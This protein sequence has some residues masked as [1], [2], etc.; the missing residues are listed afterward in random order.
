MRRQKNTDGF[1]AFAFDWLVNQR[2]NPIQRRHL[3]QRLTR[4]DYPGLVKLVLADLQRKDSGGFGSLEIHRLLL[5]AQLDEC[6]AAEPGLMNK[7]AFVSTYLCKLVP[8]DDVD[9]QYDRKA[10]VAY[11]DRVWEFVEPLDPAFN[12]LK[13]HVLYRRL[14]LDRADGVYDKSRFM[15]Y[16]KLPRHASYINPRFMKLP[17]SR[18]YAVNL[19]YDSQGATLLPPIG[20]DEPLVRS[21]L[22]HFFVKETGYKE[23]EPYVA[24]TYLKR[25]FAETKITEGSGDAVRWYAML[26]P[27]EVQALKDRIDLEFVP[28][29]L[30]VFGVD[31]E[32]RLDMHVKNVDKLIVKVF[33]INTENYYRERGREVNTDI[34]LDGLVANEEFRFEYDVPSER[35]VLRNFAFP[36]LKDRGVYVI[37]FIGN[38]I[39]SRAVVRK[40]TLRYLVRTGAAGQEFTVLNEANELVQNA[41][42]WIRGQE[43]EAQENGT[44]I[45]PFSTKPGR[46][47]LVISHDGLA[48]LHQFDHQA[49]RYEL[50]AGFYVDR[51]ALLKHRE[52]MILVRPRLLVN[53]TPVGLSNLENVRLQ[54]VSVDH[55]GTQTSKE[56]G[57]FKLHEDRESTY[58]IQ[59]PARLAALTV[60]LHAEIE[61]LS[62]NKKVPLV[63]TKQWTL[64]E[65]DRT[66]RTED[67]H[68]FQADGQYFLE[69]LGRS[70]EARPQR[71]VRIELQHRD[72][73]DT[74]TTTLQSDEAGQIALGQLEDIFRIRA[75]DIDGTTREFYLPTDRVAHYGTMHGI[76]G[77]TLASSLCRRQAQSSGSF[78][79]IYQSRHTGRGCL[80][81]G[82]VEQRVPLAERSQTG[83]LPADA[84]TRQHTN[85]HSHDQ[86]QIGPA[87]CFG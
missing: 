35:R 38:G 57:D 60:R 79:V 47:A 40:G 42:I 83:E 75:T 17:E 81:K 31:D 68:F 43:Y 87:L 53:G 51:E 27:A 21:Y 84:Q 8:S 67:L 69:V 74:V 62:L 55:D 23:Y 30:T 2:L 13:A 33:R 6:L 72:F 73:R 5:Q 29:N 46:Q 7:P 52:A 44:I 20:S 58:A 85:S 16:L 39:S 66:P 32:V 25:L 24:E 10:A 82:R 22:Q 56:V 80:R 19:N 15:E 64:N 61:Q 77:Q 14:V 45:V 4:P 1:T 76:A 59:V 70:G 34:Q 50:Q 63:A 71:P 3:L 49:E 41:T 48:A 9:W 11:L 78:I 65:I 28:T 36:Q 54:I 12:S 86:G 18:R 37:D 26:S